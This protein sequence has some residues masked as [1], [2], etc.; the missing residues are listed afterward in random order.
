M[1][2]KPKEKLIR[3]ILSAKRQYEIPRFQREYSWDKRNYMEFLEDMANNLD[4][5][6]T[7]A[8]PTS[9]FMGTMLFVG[10][11]EED[12]KKSVL[13]VDGQ[14]RLTTITILFSAIARLFHK[15][16][17]DKLSEKMFEYIMTED[18]DGQS[19]RI[20]KTVSS[21]PYFSYFIQSNEIELAGEATSEEELS[22]KQ[23]YDYFSTQLDKKHIYN[24]FKK[25]KK[26]ADD[27]EYVDLLKAIRDQVLGATIIE[28]RT[29]DSQLANN[30]FEILNAKGKQLA[31]IDLIKNKIFEYL[32]ETEPAD[33][34]R[35]TWKEIVDTLN[36]GKERTG[37]ATFFRHYWSSKYNR[38]TSKNLYDN[39]KN[40]L[41]TRLYKSFLLDFKKEALVY[42]RITNPSRDD[43]EN[44]KQ[45]YWLVQSLNSLGRFFN[46]VQVRVPL[47]ALYDAKE[48]NVISTKQFKDVVTY[49]ENFHFAYNA[50]LSKSAN[51]IDPRYSQFSIALRGCDNKQ[52][53]QAIIQSMLYNQIDQLFPNYDEFEKGFVKLTYTKRDSASNLRTKYALN[54]LNAFFMNDEIFDD[55]GSIEHI[56][57]ENDLQT[58][59]IGNLI[60]LEG[61]LNEEAGNLDYADKKSIYRKSKYKWINSFIEN[62]ADWSYKDIEK[63]ASFLAEL[64]YKEIFKRNVGQNN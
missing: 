36:T 34:A 53:S 33:F 54:K 4:I 31:Y 39:F 40:K 9:Y 44:K 35:D 28:I 60:L 45:Y 50:V 57:P 55:K 26:N 52:D 5:K 7:I 58:L 25:L 12:S 43:Y 51:L 8:K 3:E 11:S 18:D 15:E 27:V 32:D 24:I 48:R 2:I 21:Y 1:D 42:K 56:L 20:L 10:D 62:H 64:Y 59:N 46:V 14:Q 41:S 37:I 49:L 23:T 61:K 30:L 17:K 13:V 22:I 6:K 29:P 63:R 19:V 38:A 16:G 47:L